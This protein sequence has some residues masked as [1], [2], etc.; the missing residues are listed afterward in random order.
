M[1][2][3]DWTSHG[4]TKVLP[5]DS[6]R[7]RTRRSI[8]LSTDEKPTVAPWSWKAFAIPHAIEWSFATPN[9]S[10]LRPSSSPISLLS[11]EP[12]AQARL[13]S[14]HHARDA[15]TRR[16]PCVQRCTGCAACCS[17]STAC[18][19]WPARRSR[20]PRRRW[21]ALDGLGLPYLLV[22]NTSLVSRVSLAAWGRRRRLRDRRPTGSSPRCRRRPSSSGASTA[23]GPCS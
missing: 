16:P 20:A 14:A 17:T 12:L 15:P 11:A 21:T 18:S 3:S 7:G 1:S 10:A 23:I 8:R 2:A 6:A 13:P 22:T 9:T 19:C 5:I 4:S